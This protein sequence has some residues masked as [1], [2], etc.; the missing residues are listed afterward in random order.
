MDKK[1]LFGASAQA[2][3][4]DEIYAW[5]PFWGMDYE[6]IEEEKKMADKFEVG[7]K[8]R[9]VKLDVTGDLCVRNAMKKALGEF[10]VVRPRLNGGTSVAEAVFVETED[11]N[12]YFYMP[13]WLELVE[14]AKKPWNG[15]VIC[16][17]SRNRYFTIGKIYEVKKGE[18][19]D[20]S[21]TPFTH[22]LYYNCPTNAPGAYFVE[23]KGFANE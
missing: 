21:K 22:F 7:D 12:S 13:E 19:Y 17:D 20:D 11:G 23:F 6:K 9:I 5:T 14:K 10:G 16:V 18:L 2:L 1:K 8:V 3:F 4:C 15:K